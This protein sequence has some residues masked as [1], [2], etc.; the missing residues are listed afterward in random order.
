M[1]KVKDKI[2]NPEHRIARLSPS[3]ILALILFI[4]LSFSSCEGADDPIPI[5]EYYVKYEVSSSTI[6]TG[7]KLDFT[8]RTEE[9]KDLTLVINQR[10]LHET[11]IGPVEKGF[12]ASM[13]VMAKGTTFD[14][15]K[16][17]ANIYVS[18]NGSPFAL[19]KNDGSDEP[20]DLVQLSY[21][22]DY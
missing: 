18:K 6:Y 20:R 16:L 19:K 5:N 1:L 8:V 14:R 13:S 22:I 12:N 7:G 3:L 15:L 4:G 17:N 9:E 2:L 11:I 10:T 21:E